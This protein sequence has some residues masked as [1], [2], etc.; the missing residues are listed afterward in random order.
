MSPREIDA[1]VAEKV[2]G[3]KLDFEMTDDC[4]HIALDGKCSKCLTVL[5][6]HPYDIPNYSTDIAAAREVEDRIQ[7]L[8][9][10]LDYAA[11][12]LD[13][14]GIEAPKPIARPCVAWLCANASP[15]QR[16]LAA[17]RAMG[18]EVSV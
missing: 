12:L 18:V 1:L 6:E 10:H 4:D 2:L 15:R 3:L 16:C 13:I 8:R 5:A 14:I 9:L 17:L 7:A 11:H